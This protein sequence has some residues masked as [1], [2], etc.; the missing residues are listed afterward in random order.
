M[1]FVLITARPRLRPDV[2]RPDRDCLDDARETLTLATEAR[3]LASAAIDRID[4]ALTVWCLRCQRRPALPGMQVCP[5]C[6][7]VSRSSTA[8]CTMVGKELVPLEFRPSV[9]LSVR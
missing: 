2:G 6:A 8:P 1:E 5:T 4:A 3:S 9:V 7:R